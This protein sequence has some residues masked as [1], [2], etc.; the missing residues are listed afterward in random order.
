MIIR[1]IL[2][3]SYSASCLSYVA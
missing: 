1:L 2:T 3:Y